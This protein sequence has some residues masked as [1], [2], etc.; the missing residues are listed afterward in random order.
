MKTTF[1]GALNRALR[2]EMERDATVVLIGLDIGPL[3]G[4]FGV[5][6][7][8]AL[9]GRG[10]A[11]TIVDTAIPHPLAES[12][13][14]S[15]VVRIDYGADEDYTRLGEQA[16]DGW[17]SWTA[18]QFFHETGVTFLSRVPLSGFERDSYELLTRRGHLLQRR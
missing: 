15:K 5:T 7:A 12:T 4:I 18:S 16:L 8:R 10:I 13:D 17:R 3:G 14:I 9:A 11:A 2:E 1:A 6:A